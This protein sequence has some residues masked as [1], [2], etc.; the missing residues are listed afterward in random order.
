MVWD[1]IAGNWKQLIGKVQEKWGKLTHDELT[2]AAGKREQLA[3]LLQK[4]YGYQKTQAEKELDDFSRT[5]K[6]H[7]EKEIEK[8]AQTQKT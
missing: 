4:H 2:V 1:S 5:L 8:F 3:G 7:T 6:A